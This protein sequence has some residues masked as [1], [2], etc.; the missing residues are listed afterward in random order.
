MILANVDWVGWL[1]SEVLRQRW[2]GARALVAAK[3]AESRGDIEEAGWWRGAARVSF[4]WAAG[5][6]RVSALARAQARGD[7]DLAAALSLRSARTAP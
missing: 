2:I 6:V 1:R 3:G 5:L 7:W 4:V